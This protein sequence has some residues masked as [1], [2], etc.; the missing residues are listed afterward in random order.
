MNGK[1]RLPSQEELLKDYAERLKSHR[2]GRLAVHVQLSL[3]SKALLKEQHLRIAADAFHSLV[4]RHEGQLFRLQTGDLVIV[5]KNAK[6][7]DVEDAVFKVRYFFREDPYFRKTDDPDADQ[8]AVW[9]DLEKGYTAFILAMT[10]LTVGWASVANSLCDPDALDSSAERPKKPPIRPEELALIEP[11][12]ASIDFTNFYTKDYVCAL[13]EE[14]PPAP[15]FC[16][17]GVDFAALE[18]TLT[19]KHDLVSVP[20]FRQRMREIADP[21]LLALLIE[22]W[23]GTRLP[24]SLNL[25]VATVLSSEFLKFHHEVRPKIDRKILIEIQLIDAFVNMDSF[26][27]ARDF[28]RDRDYRVCL[29][30]LSPHNFACINRE[31]LMVD[32]EKI[33]WSPNSADSVVGEALADLK[34]TVERSGRNRVVLAGCDTRAAV[35]FG[36]SLGILL[37]QGPYVAQLMNKF[38]PTRAAANF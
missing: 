9:F 11:A 31:R 15:V 23:T 19:P 13:N 6:R 35:E 34:T 33:E 20:W 18:R 17:Y 37:F 22:V 27:L 26:V 21:R 12:L 25:P 38:R 14:G 29:D 1:Q 3:L 28:L 5:V 16:E 2:R 10:D 24:I 7:S 30:G 36:R 4:K 32:F 8:F